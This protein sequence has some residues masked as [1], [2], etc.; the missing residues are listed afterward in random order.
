MTSRIFKGIFLGLLVGVA[1]LVI[2]PFHFALDIEEN[3]G[4]GL[5][6]KLR[7]ARQ[8][9]SDAVVVSIDKE[10]A[11]NLNLPDNPDKWPRSL[12]ARLTENLAREGARVIAFDVHFIEPRS[13]E[14]DN[15]FAEA[16]RKAGNVVLCEPLKVKEVPLSDR[17]GSDAANHNI[18]KLVQPIDIFSSS[19][20]AT[21][22]FI[23]P[24]IPFK[25]NRYC[26]FEAGAGDSP[27]IPIIVLELFTMQVYDEFLHLL[28]KVSPDKAGALPRDIKTVIKSGGAKGLISDIRKIFESEP[29]IAER[30]LRESE[31]SNSS[32][33]V[34]THALIKSFIHMCLGS[35]SRYINYY[36]PPR[37]ITTIPYYQ[38]LQ[39]H[40]GMAGGRKIDIKDKAVFVGLSEV[41]LA[42]RKDSFYTVFSQ[43]NGIFIGGV[44]IAATAFSNLLENKPVRPLSL[45]SY[46][47]IILLWG[48]LVGGIC[49][50]SP[51][52][53]A[54]LGVVG[55]GILYLSV[56]WYQFKTGSNWYP[57]VIPLFFQAPLAFF[58]AVV[59]NY[60]ETNKERQNIR[61]AFEH[62][63]PKD[64]VNQ[65]AK[66]IAHIGT[67]SKVVYGICLYTDAEHYTTLSETM[68]PAEL[69]KFM[70]RYYEAMFRPVRAHG[71]VVST[72][73]GDSMLALW[74]AS[75]VE[76][77]LRDKACFAVLDI[78]KALQQFSRS[79]D[80][81]QLRTRIG[82]HSGQ[83]LLGNL[84]AMD[85]FQY[86]PVGDIVNSAARIEGLNKHL[87]TQALV[88]E[89]VVHQLDGFLTREVGRF[90][91][92]GKVN[93]IVIHEILCR[94]EESGETQR[95]AC[96]I[97]SEGLGAYKRRSWDEAIERFNR[98][99][100]TIG[101]D[102]P[103]LFYMKL[104]EDYKKNPPEE[105][106]DGVINMEKK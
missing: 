55:L 70:N 30:M 53:V 43:E 74:V 29:S 67:S 52:V 85:H 75:S 86:T 21:A 32:A 82:L 96:E 40:D 62:Y 71:G 16:M 81:L 101:E 1:G 72:L 104:C 49:R 76:S 28:E 100:G 50:I 84:G 3:A 22:P 12:H 39:L 80:A 48:I 37:T 93:P 33:D 91:L 26:T 10:S 63:L 4:L 99:I 73:A 7:G 83:I 19:A 57:I 15:L 66:N 95:R 46:I 98:S 34:K 69:G 24:R 90:R 31:R 51:I 77:A 68:D 11:E 44:E 87:G 18:V 6:F 106:W 35:N 97:F 56:A 61:K 60:V 47:L 17:G 54:A 94:V 102:G 58:S 14:D 36:G 8:A 41:L 78:Q 105:P 103:S 59:W 5:L 42:E 65:L 89:D 64:V 27:T 45:Y 2:C 13:A 88:S 20:V 92:K 38:A 9:P 23:L 25:V 79:S